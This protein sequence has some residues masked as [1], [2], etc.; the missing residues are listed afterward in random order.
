MTGGGNGASSGGDG[1]VWTVLRLMRW[2]GTYLEEKGVERG[3]LD[4]ELL[5]AHALDVE[6]LQLYLQFDR[7]LQSAELDRFRPLLKRRA[8]RE[9]LQ[10]IVG[11]AGFRELHLRVDPRVLIPRPETEGLVEEVLAWAA[12]TGRTGL[13]ALDLG[14]GTG[15]I[16]LSLALEGPFARVVGTD[17]SEGAL[18]VARENAADVTT[19][20]QVEFRQG[21]LYAPLGPH[22]RFDVVVSNPP[23]I[24]EAEASSLQP[25]VGEWEPPEALY[26]GP[27]G[28]AIVRGIVA[29]AGG[30]LA[31]GGL[32]ALE[33]GAGQAGPV[34]AEVEQTG[35]Y[36]EVRVRRDLSG[37]ERIVTARKP[38]GGD[39]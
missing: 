18:A 15:A 38:P 8:G 6:R 10:Y 34:V 19:D 16:A 35:E 21:S 7:P 13:S 37:R 36:E 27:D 33:I 20:G 23:Y 1:E 17:V 39:G 29:G 14:T 22:E 26:G 30:R 24:A 9:P 32:L 11:R 12:A 3:R 5:L 25:E 4:A 28:L 31:P 2:S